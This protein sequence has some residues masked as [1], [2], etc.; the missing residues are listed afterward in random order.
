MTSRPTRNQV[1]IVD[2]F[3]SDYDDLVCEFG[4]VDLV[5]FH[6]GREA[7]RSNPEIAPTM[8]VVNTQLPDMSGTDL[9]AMLRTRGCSSP[10]ALISDEYRIEDEL[11]A[12]SAGAALYFVKPLLGETLSASC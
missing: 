5:F 4:D 7:L 11:D 9:Q 8:W 3:P 10:I 2:A 12:R 1:Y 6:T